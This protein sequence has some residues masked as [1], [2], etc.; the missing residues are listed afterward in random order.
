MDNSLY[1]KFQSNLKKRGKPIKVNGIDNIAFFQEIEDSHGDDKKY[2]FTELGVV[3]QGDYIE[4]L[5]DKWLIMSKADNINSTYDKTVVQRVE[6]VIKFNY[7][8]TIRSHPAIIDTKVMDIDSGTYI[9][10]ASNKIRVTI[11]NNVDSADIAINM[12]F[13][14][15]GRAWKVTGIDKSKL[16]ILV[17]SCDLDVTSSTDDLNNEIIDRWKYETAHTYVISITNGD[18][19]EAPLNDMAQINMLVTDNGTLMATL[20]KLTFLSSDSNVVTV[21]NTGKLMGISLGIATITCQMTYNTSV[22]DTISVTVVE[23]VNHEITMS[24]SGNT[25]IKSTRT[26]SFVAHVYDNGTEIFDKPVTWGIRNQDGTTAT[27]YATITAT[28]GNGVTVKGG[29]LYPKYVVLNATL[30]ED[31][32]KFAEFTIKIASLI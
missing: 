12:K 3:N 29:S 24:I 16:G 30:N 18:S 11:P 5:N 28:S 23:N 31:V 20:P 32:T 15:T 10:T 19:M 4:A 22:K 27:A 7:S 6:C 21:D 1:R 17:L 26:D 13:I 9:S 2:M 14:N 8:G 25:T